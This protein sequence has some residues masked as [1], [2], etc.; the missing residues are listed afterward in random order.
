MNFWSTRSSKWIS[1]PLA[2]SIV[3]QLGDAAGCPAWLQMLVERKLRLTRLPGFVWRHIFQI[4]GTII[5]PGFLEMLSTKISAVDGKTEG[6]QT[7]NRSNGVKMQTFTFQES[8]RKAGLGWE[9]SGWWCIMKNK[10]ENSVWC[11]LPPQKHAALFSLKSKISFSEYGKSGFQDRKC[12]FQSLREGTVLW[13]ERQD[14]GRMVQPAHQD[15]A[16]WDAHLQPLPN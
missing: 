12:C 2:W 4:P 8:F 6:E 9:R 11:I 16:S 1:D 3:C 5:F 7:N 13:C 15:R 10:I 14:Q